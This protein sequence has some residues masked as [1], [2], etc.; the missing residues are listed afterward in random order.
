MKDAHKLLT[1]ARPGAW[2][3]QGVLG[4]VVLACAGCVDSS[5]FDDSAVIQDLG[6]DD[7]TMDNLKSIRI[8]PA[9]AV[10][11]IADGKGA[12]QAYRAIGMF[13]DGV[14]RDVTGKT[15]FMT[16]S[17]RAGGFTDNILYTAL[18]WGGKTTVQARTNNSIYATTSVTVVLSRRFYCPG[19][20]GDAASKF[21]KA[22]KGGV[23]PIVAY[24]PDKVLLP[25]NLNEL[26][27]QWVPASGQTFFEVALRNDGTDIRIYTKCVAIGSG[28]G[29][30]PISEAWKAMVNAIK[31][32]DSAQ[33]TVR[34][35]DAAFASVGTS[36][37]R[38][39]SIAEEEI[40][41]GLYYWNATPG[42]VVRYEFGKP[43]Q[44][45]TN[46][47]TRA[48]AKALFCVG[49]H[50][51]SLNG[52]RMA[53]GLDMP[54]PSPLKVLDVAS[55]T[56]L[57]SGA[58][59][60]MAFSPDGEKLITSDGRT[61][62]YREAATLKALAPTPLR[63]KGSLPDWSPDGKQVVYAEPA[64]VMP[65]PVG[66]PGIEKGSLKVMGYDA[67]AGTF[68]G[69]LTLLASA[70][71][72][73]YYPTFSP[74]NK[75]IVFNRAAGSSY[76][77]PDAALWIISSDGKGKPTELKNANLAASM[78]NSWPKFSPFLH[79]Y[80]GGSLTWL[81][82]SSRRDYG[83]RLKGKAQAQLWMAAVHITESGI[84]ID[85]SYPAFWLPFQDIRTGNH[86]AQWTQKVVKKPCG[87]DG[88]CPKGQVC[89]NGLCDF[90]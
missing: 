5:A 34:G 67:K 46:F 77:A 86:I 31:G 25:P 78:S 81:T 2:L 8:E 37:P 85:P 69:S 10:I 50:A 90:K 21:D 61:L 75:Y 64:M 55:K 58:A 30:T 74:D 57:A 1:R 65:I 24:P 33:L 59:N 40:Q 51:L 12:S 56:L 54:A 38:V 20:P 16:L 11:T 28:C 52:K 79:K 14:E 71:E 82:F 41:G 83:L 53:V 89:I 48:D 36:T 15:Y 22:G 42:S 62:V 47:Y 68:T 73:N 66:T 63:A 26:E 18:H 17:A 45:A 80:K 19:V 49:C 6:A 35:A 7:V 23:S 60:F 72:N 39:L 4:V 32:H 9:N 3:F 13:S 84:N 87:A 29:L 27:F 76:D 43:N 88:E 44:K 70:G